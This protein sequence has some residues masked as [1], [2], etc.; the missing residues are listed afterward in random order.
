MTNNQGNQ[1][2][3]DEA[4]ENALEAYERASQELPDSPEPPYNSGNTQYRQEN[5]EEARSQYEQALVLSDPELAQRSVFN[6]GN[7]LYSATQF[8]EA[9]ESYREALRLDPDDVDAK[10][11]LELALA[12]LEQQSGDEA[13]ET[14]EGPGEQPRESEPRGQEPDPQ[15]QQDGEDG[16][17]DQ[18][19]PP[20]ESESDQESGQAGD[21]AQ[22]QPGTAMTPEQARQLLE[23]LA[24]DTETLQSRLGE[25]EVAPGTPPERDW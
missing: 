17:E 9:I 11:N 3:T 13:D 23:A 22:P 7:A 1:D 8:E 25:I 14:E 21:E 10:H 12:Q 4:Y 6:I 2:F 15:D 18:D 19:P 24:G 5:F 16:E 20:G